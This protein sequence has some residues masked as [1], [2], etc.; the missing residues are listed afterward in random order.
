MKKYIGSR[1]FFGFCVGVTI[2]V[3]I[4]LL[5][6]AVEGDGEYVAGMPQLAAYFPTEC[7][8][9]AVQTAWVGLIGVTFA[10]AG[11]LFEL[12]R[13][14]AVQQYLVHFLVT[15]VVYLPFLVFCY[16]P[17]RAVTLLLVLANILLTYGITW[18]IQYSV[19][20]KNIDRINAALERRQ[21]HGG[22]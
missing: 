1:A 17:L 18:G 14:T 15:G 2:C 9:V 3:A 19:N 7:A 11:L 6:S 8:A 5:V 12:E 22:N 4:T 13:W 10:E 21:T 20:K 16:L